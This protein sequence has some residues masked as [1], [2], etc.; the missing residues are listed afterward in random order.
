MLS[1]D[2]PGQSWGVQFSDQIHSNF[3][4]LPGNSLPHNRLD[5]QLQS[6]AS[7]ILFILEGPVYGPS[8][9]AQVFSILPTTVTYGILC[10]IWLM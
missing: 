8:G 1:T 7:P 10:F 5:T 2:S 6:E 4:W 3:M 9:I